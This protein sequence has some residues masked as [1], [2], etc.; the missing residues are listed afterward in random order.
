MGT[1][2][3]DMALFMDAIAETEPTESDWTD[4]VEMRPDLVSAVVAIQN[5][6][7]LKAHVEQRGLMYNAEREDRATIYDFKLSQLENE[8]QRTGQLESELREYKERRMSLQTQIRENKAL[9]ASARI[10][11]NQYTEQEQTARRMC[12]LNKREFDGAAATHK[13]AKQHT[14]KERQIL[15]DELCE[16]RAKHSTVRRKLVDSTKAL[17]DQINQLTKEREITAAKDSEEALAL[18]SQ[19]RS[20]RQ[21]VKDTQEETASTEEEIAQVQKDILELSK[22]H[23]EMVAVARSAH[24]NYRGASQALELSMSPRSSQRQQGS[25]ERKE[26]Y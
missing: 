14:F 26:M 24:A 4:A 5:V 20:T 15:K 22:K 16:L 25:A 17:T 18:K 9:V 21:Q 7:T 6:D 1:K 8:R 12:E 3:E 10:E 2:R 19:E 23:E 11:E 13:S